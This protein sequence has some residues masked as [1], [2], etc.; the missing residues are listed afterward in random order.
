[1]WHTA[2]KLRPFP[3]L[4]TRI[5]GGHSFAFGLQQFS[6][7]KCFW[8]FKSPCFYWLRWL[9][10]VLSVSPL[11]RVKVVPR[12]SNSL[13]IIQKWKETDAL[14]TWSFFSGQGHSWKTAAL[15]NAALCQLSVRQDCVILSVVFFP[16]THISPL[17]HLHA[18]LPHLPLRPSSV[19]CQCQKDNC[20]ILCAN[21]A[22]TLCRNTK[23]VLESPHS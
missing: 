19:K 18:V 9:T 22:I 11:K 6:L 23:E 13:F 21:S 5:S 12:Q 7:H 15:W 1:M 4:S 3:V 16:V 8:V 20:V 17:L 10:Q 2:V 14:T